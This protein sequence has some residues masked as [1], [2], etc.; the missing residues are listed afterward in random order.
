M[1]EDSTIAPR[2]SIWSRDP[3]TDLADPHAFSFPRKLLL[4]IISRCSLRCGH[5]VRGHFPSGQGEVMSRQTLDDVVRDFFP[6]VSTA[7]LGGADLGE[8][9]QSPHFDYLLQRAQDHPGLDLDMITSGVMITRE[10]ASLIAKSM[11]HVHLSLEGVGRN[12][13]R[14]RGIRWEAA[15]QR[16]EWLATQRDAPT[17]STGRRLRVSLHVSVMREC[18][19]DCHH[20]VDLAG[21]LRI[22]SVDFRHFIPL[23]P[24]QRSSSLLY[25]PTESN[26][27]FH[28]LA[29]HAAE[30][31]VE[32]TT[33]A[34]APVQRP[35]EAQ[36]RRPCHLP[37]ET[38]GIHAD[39]RITSCC[40]ASLRLGRC[41]PGHAQIEKT[42][43]G[44][45]YARLRA[46]VN[47][48]HPPTACARCDAFNDDPLVY[49]PPF[50]MA[51]RARLR[52]ERVLPP[53]VSRIFSRS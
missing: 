32:I 43:T 46:T 33:P 18:Q 7:W 28:E 9:M 11:S 52:L 6:R 38:L 5:C 24:A 51:D 4:S 41:A 48:A 35:R 49:R 20:L 14:I 10:R 2:S 44:P 26:R 37:F 23:L 36:S 16:L 47:S 30:A 3:R 42:W 27:F 8:Q 31:G 25:S 15:L 13:T 17:P 50:G 53:A 29:D 19:D 22:R 39:G 12:Y 1:S 34:E 21:L 40:N 45:R